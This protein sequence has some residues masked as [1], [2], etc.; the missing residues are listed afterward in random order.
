M[1]ACIVVL[2]FLS[3]AWDANAK[4]SCVANMVGVD[5]CAKAKEIASEFQKHL[6]IVMSHNLS[7]VSA[8]AMGP[9]V[10]IQ[11]KHSL[12]KAEVD[13]AYAQAGMDLRRSMETA[14]TGII[15]EEES[16]TRA[17]VNL[18]GEIQYLYLFSD[19][20]SLRVSIKSCE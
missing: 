12:A 20:Q 5:I 1:K 14:T 9:L 2:T 8:A 7:I 3:I 13:S 4:D 19:L 18:G 6:P 16:P 10:A 11:A 17:F 15:C